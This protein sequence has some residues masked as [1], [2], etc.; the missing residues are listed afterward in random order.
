MD[1]FLKVCDI[2]TIFLEVGVDG[3]EKGIGHLGL[4]IKNPKIL[5]VWSTDNWVAIVLFIQSDNPVVWTS[6]WERTKLNTESSVGSVLI[7]GIGVSFANNLDWESF[8]IAGIIDSDG[9]VTIVSIGGF[10]FCAF[11]LENLRDGCLF[12]PKSNVFGYIDE[13][14]CGWW[15]QGEIRLMIISLWE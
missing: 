2:E 9:S 6:R 1:C 12:I 3:L 11:L 10:S 4:S 14:Y 15:I 13:G 8:N 7:F 5:I